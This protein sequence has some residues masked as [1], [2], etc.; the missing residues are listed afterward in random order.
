MS[1]AQRRS[2]T[3]NRELLACTECRRRKLRCDRQTPCSSCAK[4]GDEASCTYQRFANRLE[5]ERERRVEADMRLESLERFVQ[6]LSQNGDGFTL[7]EENPPQHATGTQLNGEGFGAEPG[8]SISP[9][10]VFNG[11]THWSL[12]LDDIQGLRS[13]I[14][15][16]EATTTDN[17]PLDYVENAGA[18]LILGSVIHLSLQDVL[19]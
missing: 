6:R 18:S 1:D 14:F 2:I 19:V 12:M 7:R 13:A 17:D 11:S 5:R 9:G 10:S 16:S 8:V 4:R 3:R 15:P